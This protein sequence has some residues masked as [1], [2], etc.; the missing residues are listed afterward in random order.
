MS[1]K[2]NRLTRVSKEFYDYN[3]NLKKITGLPCTK[4]SELFPN[5]NARLVSFEKDNKRKKGKFV[6]E[7]EFDL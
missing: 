3:N 2:K 5:N 1:K 7:M 6:W 4:L